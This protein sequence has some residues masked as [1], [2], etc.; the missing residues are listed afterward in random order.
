MRGRDGEKERDGERERWRG[1]EGR[2]GERETD[3]ERA[4]DG[5]G[6]KYDIKKWFRHSS[7]EYLPLTSIEQTCQ[8]QG[9]QFS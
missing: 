4:R 9:E 3:R 1:G 8:R 5:E 2:G 6:E 7:H